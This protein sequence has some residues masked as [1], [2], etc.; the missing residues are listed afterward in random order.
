MELLKNS[1]YR[2][3]NQVL[4]DFIKPIIVIHAFFFK[5]KKKKATAFSYISLE[6]LQSHECSVWKLPSSCL[7]NPPSAS[8]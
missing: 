5:K 1:F 3:S 7:V 8:A 6:Y 4:I 2:S